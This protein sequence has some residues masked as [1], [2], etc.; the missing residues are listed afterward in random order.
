MVS[1][2]IGWAKCKDL[3]KLGLYQHILSQPTTV[4]TLI[5]TVFVEYVVHVDKYH[6]LFIIRVFT[7]GIN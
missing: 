1:V 4:I 5:T 3:V 7:N 2:S 6:N